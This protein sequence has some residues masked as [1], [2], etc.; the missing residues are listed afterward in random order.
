[1]GDDKGACLEYTSDEPASNVKDAEQLVSKLALLCV[2]PDQHDEAERQHQLFCEGNT[3]IEESPAPKK[4]KS[5]GSYSFADDKCR[6]N[7]GAQMLL[8]RAIRKG[9]VT[10][11]VVRVPGS[12]PPTWVATV[13]IPEFDEHSR[14]EGD[15]CTD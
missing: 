12:E 6:L 2:R 8:G 5:A 10:Y 13:A 1:M 14:Y 4:L 15:P 3:E 9:D 11:E 7:H